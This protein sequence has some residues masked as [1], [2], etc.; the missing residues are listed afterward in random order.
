MKLILLAILF[1]FCTRSYSQT[2]MANVE[3]RDCIGLNGKWQVI[4]DPYSN[5]DW[6][7]IWKDKKATGKTDFIE[8]AFNEK[9]TLNV[10]G[11][12]NSQLPELSYYENT[13]W[14]KKTFDYHPKNKRLF[15]HFGAVNYK[16]DVYLNNQKLGSHE[17][18]FTPFQFEITNL[19]KKGSNSIIVRVNDARLKDAIPALGYDWFNYGGIT[20]DVN[21]I[22]TPTNFIEDYFIQLQKGSLDKIVGWV[23]IEGETNSQKVHIQI[24][25][26][27]IDK[28]VTTAANGKADFSFPIKCQLW[29][30]ETP[31]LYK[32][33]L[34]AE[35]DTL[36][37][38]IGF[39]N[40]EVKGTDI[41]LNGRP[42]FLKGVNFHEEIPQRKARA[43][44]ESDALQLITSAK[45]LGCNFIRTA[46]YPQNEHTVRLAEKMGLMIWEEIPV[47]Q[48]IA[49]GDTSVPPKINTMLEEMVK[50][51]K[52]RCAI[53]IWSMS[54]ETSPG[55]ARD[56][57]LTNVVQHCRSLDST[58]L[59]SSAFSHLKYSKDSLIINDAL[60]QYLDVLAVNEY[61][62]WY[63]PWHTKGGEM[64]FK[65]NFNKPLIMT[66]FGAEALYGNHGSADTASSWSEE[67]QEQVYKDQ[68]KMFGN[69]SF[70]RGTC[71]WILYDFRAPGR[72]HPV[73]QNGWNRK[74]LL[75]EQGFKKKAWYVMKNFYSGK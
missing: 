49:F 15:L 59:V 73:F 17:G 63:V 57:V 22:E 72:M 60:G 29:S 44:S 4:I 62:G 65:S 66:E 74:G 13:M 28:L 27:K 53:I 6:M 26:L 68:I 25:E 42:I 24:P 71:P 50:R 48:Q 20:R 41:I 31:R 18:G 52:N 58:R 9:T 33:K 51:D 1:C 46:H 16:S 75:S 14:Y 40:I 69:I 64:V 8:Y 70:L 45:E 35:T 19:V 38:E 55:K 43:Y 2:A 32:V 61:L 56:S 37:D 36:S 23:K 7:G 21:L 5:G 67:Y 12:Y 3:G 39:R 10:P 11:D 34:V 47:W 54:N 30:P